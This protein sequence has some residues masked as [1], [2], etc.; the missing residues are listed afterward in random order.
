MTAIV[1]QVGR[2][3]VLT[4]VAEFEPVLLAGTTVRRATLHNYEDLS[5]KDVRVGDTVAVEKAGDVIP[6][7]TRVLLEKRPENAIPFEMPAACP[8]CGRRRKPLALAPRGRTSPE[9]IG[10]SRKYKV[11]DV[12]TAQPLLGNPVAAFIF[13]TTTT[14]TQI[15]WFWFFY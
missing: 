1:V 7:V 11:V 10:M 6:K 8:E 9:R 12:F 15:I 3:G 13:F 14:R 2:T 4:P 5:R